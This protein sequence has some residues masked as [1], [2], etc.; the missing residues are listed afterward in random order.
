MRESERETGRERERENRTKVGSGGER[1]KEKRKGMKGKGEMEECREGCLLYDK[2]TT[3]KGAE[4]SY[5]KE[6]GKERKKSREMIHHSME[7]FLSFFFL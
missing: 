6:E 3:S 7:L 1:K 5:R 2:L 4:L